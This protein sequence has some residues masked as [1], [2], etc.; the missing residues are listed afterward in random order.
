MSTEHRVGIGTRIAASVATLGMVV[1]GCGESNAHDA[2]KKASDKV[3]EVGAQVVDQAK[4]LVPAAGAAEVPTT[5]TIVLPAS[6]VVTVEGGACVVAVVADVP[7]TEQLNTGA[8]AEVG[9]AATIS[10]GEVGSD[11]TEAMTQD[12]RITEAQYGLVAIVAQQY[13]AH[14]ARFTVDMQNVGSQPLS[15]ANAVDASALTTGGVLFSD[16]SQ[17]INAELFGRL[18]GRRVDASSAQMTALRISQGAKVIN[19]DFTGEQTAGTVTS[20]TCQPGQ[21]EAL[22]P[23]TIES[24]LG[25]L[26][27][28]MKPTGGV[29]ES[30]QVAEAPSTTV[31]G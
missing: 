18:D 12:D 14:D 17:G 15:D 30:A 22:S 27:Q 28:V 13:A 5:S 9:D 3:H 16:P 2:A 21:A 1:A 26:T 8:V 31:S 4:N 11:T 20:D 23:E 24:I 29:D 10:A 7:P 6:P 25:Q 19:I